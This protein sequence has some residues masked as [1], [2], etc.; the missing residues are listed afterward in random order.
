MW[1][2]E[3]RRRRLRLPRSDPAG[4]DRGGHDSGGPSGAPGGWATTVQRTRRNPPGRTGRPNGL[5]DAENRVDAGSDEPN[6]LPEDPR[7]PHTRPPET[8]YGRGTEAAAPGVPQSGQ[9]LE[10]LS[11][12]PLHDARRLNSLSHFGR[13]FAA[14]PAERSEPSQEPPDAEVEP[15]P[16]SP[17]ARRTIPDAM[18]RPGRRIPAG[19]V[20]HHALQVS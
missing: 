11:S 18:C 2:D 10:A 15:E 9:G 6:G 3:L 16:E 12:P 5:P 4:A 8:C 1:G 19:A 17:T 13:A 20:D 14:D 7:G